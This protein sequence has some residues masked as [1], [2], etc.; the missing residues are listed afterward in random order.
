[1]L[2]VG[3]VTGNT[4]VATTK[5]EP[6]DKEEGKSFYWQWGRNCSRLRFSQTRAEGVLCSTG[7]ITAEQW[8]QFWDG[9]FAWGANAK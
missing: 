1:M 9:F 6:E 2:S 8:D 3:F 4:V 7:G 5:L